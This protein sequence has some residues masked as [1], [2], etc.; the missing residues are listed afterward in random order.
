MKDPNRSHLRLHPRA[1]TV[2]RRCH[3]TKPPRGPKTPPRRPKIPPRRSKMPSRRPKTSLRRSKR[4]SRAAKTAKMT[5]KTPPRHDFEGFWEPK[6]RHVGTKIASKST[7]C[8]KRRKALWYWK[9]YYFFVPWDQKKTI[10]NRSKIVPK[11]K[12]RWE[13]LL[14]RIFSPFY[15]FFGPKTFQTS[16]K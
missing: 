14:T 11:L 2:P 6:W 15:M 8:Q 4:P 7:S 3:R 1:T 16:P 12:S 9:S 10:Q 13:G 5:P